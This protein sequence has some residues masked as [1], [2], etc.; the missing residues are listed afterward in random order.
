MRAFSSAPFEAICMRHSRMQSLSCPAS[1]CATAASNSSWVMRQPMKKGRAACRAAPKSSNERSR[2]ELDGVARPVVTADGV[3][4]IDV[5][6]GVE[7]VVL[8]Q[9]GRL[10]VG[11][12]VDTDLEARVGRRQRIAELHAMD[13]VSAV[14]PRIAVLRPIR[15][16]ATR[17]GAGALPQVVAA[18]VEA[19]DVAGAEPCR[20]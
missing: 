10:L 13:H 11:Q 18:H 4:C 3:E 8:E 12:I 19:T 1:Y 20:E 2:S 9:L 5:G 6:V 7:H 16:A 14:S 17:I 15:N